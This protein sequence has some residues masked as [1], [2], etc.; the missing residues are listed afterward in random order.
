MY[1]S[2]IKCSHKEKMWLKQRGGTEMLQEKEDLFQTLKMF[3]SLNRDHKIAISASIDAYR[4]EELMQ[5]TGEAKK[6]LL[7]V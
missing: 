7:E 6:E 2:V 5:E 1:E 3:E 4:R